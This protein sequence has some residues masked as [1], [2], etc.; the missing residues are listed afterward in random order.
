MC[1][2]L[3]ACW[4][5]AGDKYD[6]V[7]MYACMLAGFRIDSNYRVIKM[8][9]VVWRKSHWIHPNELCCQ[10]EV[11]L[12]LREDAMYVLTV[13]ADEEVE[14]VFESAQAFLKCFKHIKL[15]SKLEE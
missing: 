14:M 11:R 2:D 8:S 7:Q 10:P 6:T 1:K 9:K 5:H 4:A 12:H 3:I 13:K 15:N